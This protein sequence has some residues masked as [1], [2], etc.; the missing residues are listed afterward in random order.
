MEKEVD[1]VEKAEEAAEE[2]TR[3]ENDKVLETL[4]P[5]RMDTIYEENEEAETDETTA[6]NDIQRGRPHGNSNVLKIPSGD[7]GI[8]SIARKKLR[9]PRGDPGILSIARRS[10]RIPNGDPGILSIATRR[11]KIPEGN[12]GIPSIA[13]VNKV[14]ALK[15]TP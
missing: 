3:K 7:P 4:L 8:L 11:L 14:P 12:P 13:K 9:I 1:V 10:L 15:D 6:D 5:M 2:D